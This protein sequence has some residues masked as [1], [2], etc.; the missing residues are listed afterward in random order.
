MALRLAFVLLLG[1]ALPSSALAEN[2]D[3]EKLVEA[4]LLRPGQAFRD[5]SDCPVMVVVPAGNFVMG[6][7]DF[8]FS[9]PPHQVTIREPFAVGKYE[10]TFAEWEA[11]VAGGGCT[12][13]R[14][15]DDRGRGRGRRPVIN[16]TW[17]DA[18]E[19]VAWLS[20][21]TGKTYRLLS[22]AEWEYVAQAGATKQ[23]G[24]GR[25]LEVGSFPANQFGLHD[26]LGNVT[27]WVEDTWH[28]HYQGAPDDG[29]TWLGGDTSLRGLRG[30]FWGSRTL[31]PAIRG[32][33]PPDSTNGA[34]GFRLA[35][36]LYP[37][38]AA[39]RQISWP[40]T[41]FAGRQHQGAR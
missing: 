3:Y 31:H 28:P 8:V 25:A 16:V 24:V 26:L 35:T 18:K 2:E 1:L 11:C 33:A 39:R 38:T 34:T 30:G 13:N 10:V 41:R 14:W 21:R 36:T 29:S 32:R 23:Y 22:E 40:G 12:S 4:E 37:L 6:S 17:H 9:K 15:P 20:R 19:Y 27:E 7:T 5:C